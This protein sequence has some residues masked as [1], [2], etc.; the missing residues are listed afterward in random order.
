[1]GGAS[2]YIV[3]AVDDIIVKDFIDFNHCITMLEQTKAY[4]FYLRLG[5]N[6]TECYSMN[7]LQKVPPFLFEKNGI[8]TWC[9]DEGEFDW[10]YPHTV[11]MTVYRRADIMQSLMDLP[12]TSPNTLEGAW[13]AQP[14]FDWK[15]IGLCYECSKIVNIPLNRVQHEALNNHM[16]LY[17]TDELLEKF[18]FGLKIDIKPLF[19]ISNKAAHFEYEPIFIL[20]TSV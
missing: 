5:K 18:Q 10:G 20:R 8:C 3:F 14:N 9:F 11:D 12:F 1:M 7:A 6:L 4:G 2:N 16:N 13:S 17:T 19:N 15:R